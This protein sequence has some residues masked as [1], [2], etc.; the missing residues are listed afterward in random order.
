MGAMATFTRVLRSIA[1]GALIVMML[2]TVI[3]ISMRLALN[4]L[5]LGSVEIVEW[6][7]VAVVF[8]GLP[9]TFLRS[10]HITVDAIDQFVSPRAARVLRFAGSLLTLLLLVVMAGRMVPIAL[11]T[12]VIGDLT[13][14]LQKSLFWYWLPILIGGF[15]SV[16][17]MVLVVIKDFVAIDS[18][19][20]AQAETMHVE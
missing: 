9:E 3:D 17:A 1:M 16:V 20:A 2:V 7:I 14:D 15:A 19:S 11:D 6:M 8:L 10:E 12:L 18:P 4:E 5:V 13:T